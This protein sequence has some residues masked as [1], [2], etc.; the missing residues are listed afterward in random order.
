MATPNPNPVPNFRSS[1]GTPPPQ[2]FID[3][4]HIAAMNFQ[5]FTD[6]AVHHIIY[7]NYALGTLP[8][9]CRVTSGSVPD[10]PLMVAV[11]DILPELR[12]LIAP[13]IAPRV[14]QSLRMELFDGKG[15]KFSTLEVTDRNVTQLVKLSKMPGQQGLLVVVDR[16]KGF[17]EISAAPQM[18]VE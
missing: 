9:L 2:P 6:R 4:S 1:I 17:S 8:L 14:I 7:S 15:F 10:F 5:H 11:D 18:I 3:H 16:P 12:K 13:V